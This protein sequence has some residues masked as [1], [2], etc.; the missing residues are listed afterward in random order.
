MREKHLLIGIDPHC[1]YETVHALRSIG[2]VLGQDTGSAR[3]VLVS[4]VGELPVA[5][6]CDTPSLPGSYRSIGQPL[7]IDAMI[8]A[9]SLQAKLS[10]TKARTIARTCG[11]CDAHIDCV[12]RQGGT[13]EELTRVACNYHVDCIV[14]GNRG[15]SIWQLLRRCVT[16]S[17]SRQ[18][19]A[20][21][22]C[23]VLTIPVSQK[24][25][26]AQISNVVYA[27]PPLRV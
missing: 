2:E 6:T 8:S 12:M 17:L 18:L 5:V 13:A 14:L 26:L 4:V 21:A 3:L 19:T 20:T 10:L 7:L 16:G 1:T 27:L 24:P 23:P 15:D 9:Q 11:F 25:S 22:P